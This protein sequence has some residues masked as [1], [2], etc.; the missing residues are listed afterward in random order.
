MDTRSIIL[1]RRPIR[2][3]VAKVGLDGHEVGARVVARGLMDAG[4]EVIYTGLRRTPEQVAEV[5]LQEDSDVIGISI[6]SGAHVPLV[7]RVR[8]LME[9]TGLDDVLLIVGGVI[10]NADVKELKEIGVDEVF[11]PATTI[12]EIA[13]FI[14]DHVRT[15]PAHQTI[16]GNG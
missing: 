10:P 16:G 12:D 6:L 9:E 4:M 1:G 11:H 13:S 5:A 8:R 2:V 15:N 14:C 7:R 3:V